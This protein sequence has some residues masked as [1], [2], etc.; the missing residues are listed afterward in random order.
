MK[1]WIEKRMVEN[2]TENV[3]QLPNWAEYY[4]NLL[5]LNIAIKEY[6]EINKELNAVFKENKKEVGRS[7]DS[8]I[9]GR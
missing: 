5:N 6:K 4:N 1:E 7:L 3:I 8:P 9:T 2:M